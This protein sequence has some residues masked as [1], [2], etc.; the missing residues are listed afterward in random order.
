MTR[1]IC[2]RTR[3]RRL[4]QAAQIIKQ[5][6]WKVQIEGNAMIVVPLS[7]TCLSVNAVPTQRSRS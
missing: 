4:A 6:G 5:K 2:V 1:L 7:T 3:N